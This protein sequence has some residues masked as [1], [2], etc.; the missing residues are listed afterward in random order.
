MRTTRRARAYKRGGTRRGGGWKSFLGIKKNK[1]GIW[2][3][4]KNEIRRTANTNH[5]PPT[6]NEH[7]KLNAEVS[8]GYANL[9][10]TIKNKA[11][12]GMEHVKNA[13]AR[14]P[15]NVPPSLDEDLRKGERALNKYRAAKT[16]KNAVNAWGEANRVFTALSGDAALKETKEKFEE[17]M[18]K[19]KCVNTKNAAWRNGAKPDC[20]GYKYYSEEVLAAK[21]AEAAKAA[22]A[23][24]E[25]T[26]GIAALENAANANT[27]TEA[28]TFIARALARTTR[29]S[30]RR[31]K[32]NLYE[33]LGVSKDATMADI[34]RGYIKEGLSLEKIDPTHEKYPR[35]FKTL[36]EVYK[37]LSNPRK[38][39]MYDML[40]M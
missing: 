31:K 39:E 34:T 30:N 40:Y 2:K 36:K 38:R 5:K 33:I 8:K 24:E 10:S 35:Y 32:Y 25:A 28:Q 37:F 16:R 11:V 21:A 3:N 18:E 1:P 7:N 19:A 4:M 17:D 9:R 22:K 6:K 15:E 14:A 12:R 26:V 20:K 29:P 13:F 23:V 27:T